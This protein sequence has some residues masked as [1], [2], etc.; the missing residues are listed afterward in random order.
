LEPVQKNI[1]LAIDDEQAV[2]RTVTTALAMAGFRAIVAENGVAGL[3][4]FMRAKAEICLV[5]SDI[6]M[7]IMTGVE[8]AERIIAIEPDVKVLL[9]SGYSNDVIEVNG[10][11]RFPFIRKPFLPADLIMKIQNLLGSAA[12]QSG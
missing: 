1:V 6:I 2:L 8:M 5:L 11:K 10:R 9:M 4:S 7:P 12:S 3:E